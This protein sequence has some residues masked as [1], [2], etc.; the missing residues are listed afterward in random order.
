MVKVSGCGSGDTSSILVIRLFQ[1]NRQRELFV[2][3]V[4]KTFSRKDNQ[5]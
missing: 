1:Y 3:T 2:K 4:A 5:P